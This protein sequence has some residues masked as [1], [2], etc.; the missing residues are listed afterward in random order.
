MSTPATRPVI[1]SSISDDKRT[2]IKVGTRKS[3]LALKQADWIVSELTKLHPDHRFE[4]HG[5]HSTADK[6]KITALYKFGTQGL[7]TNELEAGLMAGELDII[8][9]CLKDMPTS[10]PEGCVL[11]CVTEREDPRDV[12]VVKKALE[13]KYKKLS[14]LPDGSVVGTSSVRRMA[15]ISRHYP[16]L[17]FMDMRGNIDTRLRKLDAED[18]EYTVL[19][20]AAAGLHR[21]GLEGRV[22]QYL[23]G[24]TE[25]GGMLY[26]V[27]QGALGIEVRADDEK[28]IELLRA[29]E[30]EENMLATEVERSIM[31]TLEGGCSVPIGVETKWIG[32]H[33]LSVSATVVSVDG[34]EGADAR[35]E[36]EI[37]S[38]EQSIEF[39]KEVAQQLV[40][41]GAQKILVV[42][43]ADRAANP[44]TE[45]WVPA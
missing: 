34:K 11:A 25:G 16:K 6:D 14:D 35:L 32:E 43:N 29:F 12:V 8:V 28:T 27:G 45:P 2:L 24:D 39:G 23:D 40:D 42:I 13:G 31:R 30:N 7:W 5:M 4:V 19:I 33:K 41:N 37:K 22:A 44:S 18:S 3:A 1:T 26:A 17:K 15:Q 36:K 20:L 9:H 38:R 21:M 10:L